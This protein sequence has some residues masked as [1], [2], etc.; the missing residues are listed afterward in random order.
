MPTGTVL[1]YDAL[2]TLRRF[3][4][5]DAFWRF[6]IGPVRSGKSTAC[7]MELMRRACE[8]APGPD[9]IRRSRWAVVRQ[10]YRELED[11]TLR[12]WLMWFPAEYFGTFYRRSM[13]HLVVFNDVQAEILFRA[14]DKPKDVSHLLSLELT[15]AWVNE[16]RE[17]PKGIIDALGDRV[18]Q[19]PPKRDGGCTWRGVFGDTNPPDDDH[20]IYRLAE[21]ERPDGWAFFRQ[22]G[23]LIEQNGTFV[24][25]PRAENMSNLQ[26]GYKYYLDRLPG[27][28][29]D[30]VRVYYCGQYGFVKEGKPVF[31]EYVDAV[32]CT[33]EELLPVPGVPLIIGL[34]FGLTPAA[35]ITQRLPNG[36]WIWI[37]ELISEDCGIE[38][39]ADLY[40]LP[41]LQGRYRGFE[42]QVWG[43]PAGDERAQTDKRTPFQILRAKGIDAKPAPSN[44]PVLRIGAV[45]AALTRMID[46]KPGLLISPRCRTT[47][48]GMAGGYHYQRI[49]VSGDARYRDKPAKNRFS[50]PCD[51]AQY[52]MLG[53]GEGK[54]MTTRERVSDQ[55]PGTYSYREQS[56]TSWMGA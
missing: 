42:F 7:S 55:E 52:A 33:S 53:A 27:K 56:A 1:R 13:T 44:D 51:A 20:W 21:V 12:T 5:S 32:H 34:D 2:P 18:G 54:R 47:R 19:Y 36:R 30:Y 40:L 4:A 6:V 48:K 50:H 45:S 9:G 3:H 17:I 15:G 16:A 23:G 26:E 43:D 10:T 14:L 11:T 8:Q 49:Q 22:P 24:P 35:V 46:G 39:F 38:Q 37:D 29:P 28:A 25:N 41:A 31:P